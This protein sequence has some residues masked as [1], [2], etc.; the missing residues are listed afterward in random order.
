LWTVIDKNRIVW[1]QNWDTQNPS[2]FASFWSIV[3]CRKFV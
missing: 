1:G 3:F 2:V